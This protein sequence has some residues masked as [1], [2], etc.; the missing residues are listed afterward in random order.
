MQPAHRPV[1]PQGATIYTV[2]G[3]VLCIAYG[4]PDTVIANAV[5]EGFTAI[6][7]ARDCEA[8][9]K[10]GEGHNDDE[11]QCTKLPRAK[12]KLHPFTANSLQRKK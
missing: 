9:S 2:R 10:D 11:K 3:M 5:T 12:Y 8:R 4:K 1:I 6:V 7:F